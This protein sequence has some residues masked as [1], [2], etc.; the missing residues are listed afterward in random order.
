MVTSSNVT[1]TIDTAAC[2]TTGCSCST[3]PGLDYHVGADGTASGPVG[4]QLRVNINAPQGG[5]IDCGSWTRV[6]GNTVFGCDTIGCCQRQAGEPDSMQWT[7]FEVIDLPCFCPSFPSAD[8][9]AHNFIAQCQ[10][11]PGPVTE[12]PRTS[13]PCP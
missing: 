6:F 5:T 10:L 12:I 1:C 3:L 13:T 2:T 4:T 7:V 11:P 8:Q 9:L